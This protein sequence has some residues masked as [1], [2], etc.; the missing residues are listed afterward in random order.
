VQKVETEVDGVGEVPPTTKNTA[1][2]PERDL[3]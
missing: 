2:I 1:G 3:V